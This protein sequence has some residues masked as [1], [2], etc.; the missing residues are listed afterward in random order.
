MPITACD[1]LYERVLPFYEKLGITVGAVLTDNGREFCGK[2]DQHPY[3]LLLAVE[4]IKHRTTKV[5]C[6]RTNGF[7]ERMNRTLL[8]EC[9]RVQGRQK[10]YTAPE[11]IQADLDAFMAV[12]NFQR[13]HQGYRV[14][15]RTPAQALLDLIA[16]Q[17]LL[18]SIPIAV[19][20]VPLASWSETF[21]EGLGVG[22]ILDLHP[23]RDGRIRTTRRTGLQPAQTSPRYRLHPRWK[24]LIT[25]IGKSVSQAF[26]P[27]IT[28]TLEIPA[29]GITSQLSASTPALSEVSRTIR[30]PTASPASF[31]LLLISRAL[32]ALTSRT[33]DTAATA[34]WAAAT[35]EQLSKTRPPLSRTLTASSAL[36]A[37]LTMTVVSPLAE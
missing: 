9:F 3:E 2:P 1:T 14:A 36:L 20:E 18:P 16:A 31:L 22:E 10:W 4:G 34:R 37:P 12:H 28:T 27:S 33:C 19:Q 35:V 5:R 32:N 6:P 24:K 8:D 23:P 11:E 21:P 30:R 17:R 29:A 7:V 15:G 13:S 25:S 26:V